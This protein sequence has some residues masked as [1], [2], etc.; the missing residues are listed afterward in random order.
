MTVLARSTEAGDALADRIIT[1]PLPGGWR[2]P[3]FPVLNPATGA[4]LTDVADMGPDEAKAAV[5]AASQAL[6]SWAGRTAKERAAILMAWHDR[7]L[8]NKDELARLLTLEMGKPLAE[9]AGEVA[10][11][12]SY[13]AW[14]AEEAK[15]LYGDVIP[16]NDPNRRMLAIRQP[17]GVV[18][19]IT[20]WNFPSAM[21]MR[22]VAPALA[23]GCT[24]VIKPA[25]DTPLS[26]IALLQLAGEA[27]MPEGVLSLVTCR[28]PAEIARVLTDHRDVRKLSFTGSTAVGKLLM[29][30]CADT[31]K[32][33]SLELG[34]NAPFIVFA[35]ADLDTAVNSAMLAKFRNAGQTCISANRF[36]VEASVLPAFTEKLLARIAGLKAGDGLEAGTSLGPIINEAGLAKI[37]R[38]VTTAMEQGATLLTGGYRIERPGTFYAPTVLADV[39][40]A[41]DISKAEIFGPVV[42]LSAF[43][44]E[45]E[46]IRLANDTD[47]GL[48]AYAFTREMGRLWRLPE[49]LEF[50][51]V[52]MNEGTVGSEAAPFGGVKE[53]GIGREG[54][55]VGIDE[56]AEIKYV[57]MGGI[58]A[59]R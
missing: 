55:R 21:I 46:A 29:R 31:V 15:R 25:E 17:I 30:Q 59:A 57:G 49:A 48:A 24:V 47:Y 45:A 18:A 58:G 9:A 38:L 53:S 2:G 6:A 39:T 34:G 51:M 8:Q 35:D 37:D 1:C 10:H 3:T 19:A 12:A 33:V 13:I 28:K 23:A 5:K 14:F 22:K 36:L 7:I 42:T 40:P 26:A 20:P 43:E 52:A 32:K 4:H 11:G 54:S 16:T 41:M 44:T 50:G 56:Y 27:G